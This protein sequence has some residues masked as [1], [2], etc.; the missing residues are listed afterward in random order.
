MTCK[1][2]SERKKEQL[3]RHNKTSQFGDYNSRRLFVSSIVFSFA[4]GPTGRTPLARG[5]T[6]ISVTDKSACLRE[7]YRCTTAVRGYKSHVCARISHFDREARPLATSKT[8]RCQP[9]IN[10]IST[11]AAD[12]FRFRASVSISPYRHVLRA[13][14]EYFPP[15]KKIAGVNRDR[16]VV[17]FLGDLDRTAKYIARSIF[18]PILYVAF[19]WSH[20]THGVNKSA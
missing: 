10:S 18:L 4:L 9:V 14:R 2:K 6:D 16:A 20:I 3:K 1:R 17:K 13:Y 12:T 7:F 11:C 15:R 8:H 19:K 5:L